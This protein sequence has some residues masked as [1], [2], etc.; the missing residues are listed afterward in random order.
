MTSVIICSHHECNALLVPTIQDLDRTIEVAHVTSPKELTL[1]YLETRSPDWIFF[2]HWSWKV[3]ETI[4]SKYR[5]VIFHMTDLPFGRGGTPL[6]N[7]IVRGFKETKIC[8]LECEEG[9]DTG[10]IYCRRDLSLEGSAEE[11]L[12]R[13]NSTIAEMISDIISTTPTPVAQRGEVVHFD[14]R[15]PDQSNLEELCDLD[16]IYDHIRMLDAKGYPN[17]YLSTAHH[18]YYFTDVRWAA[19]ELVAE[20][21]IV[22]RSK[23]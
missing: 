15:T 13:A 4:F 5:C 12:N 17:A 16:S 9:I 23:P 11:I 3:P 18:T 10:P 8:A 14:R 19:G 7:L 20:V 21:R 2:P 6:Q 1:D 22:K